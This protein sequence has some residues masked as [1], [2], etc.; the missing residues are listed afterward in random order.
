MLA[1]DKAEVIKE[2][3]ELIMWDRP[4]HLWG[5]I[6]KYDA[7]VCLRDF[8]VKTMEVAEQE[9]KQWAEKEKEIEQDYANEQ[10]RET[11]TERFNP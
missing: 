8:M 9:A 5:V 2:C 1:V 4:Q 11:A 10:R 6:W 7:V 3:I